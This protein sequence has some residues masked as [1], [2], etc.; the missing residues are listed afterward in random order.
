ALSLLNR[1]GVHTFDYLPTLTFAAV[2]DAA[3]PATSVYSFRLMQNFATR[4]YAAD[5]RQ[6]Q[7][8]LAVAVGA[9]DKLFDAAAFAPAIGAQRADV[10]VTVVAGVGHVEMTTDLRGLAAI[11]AAIPEDSDRH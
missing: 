8:P 3:D 7:C 1:A 10:P 2:P 9:E 11:I 4:D 5:L 6:A